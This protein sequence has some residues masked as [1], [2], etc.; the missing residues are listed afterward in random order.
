MSDN[1]TMITY[2]D[3]YK[4]NDIANKISSKARNNELSLIISPIKHIEDIEHYTKIKTTSIFNVK[5]DENLLNFI[6][7]KR[8]IKYWCHIQQMKE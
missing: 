2:Q 6:I 8:N 7:I 4:L 5:R 3:I 1:S